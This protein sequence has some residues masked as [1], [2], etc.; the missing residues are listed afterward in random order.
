MKKI[1]ILDSTLR[2]GAQGEGV[3][4]SVKDKIYICQALD[5]LGVDFIEAGNPGSN[6]PAPPNLNSSSTFWREGFHSIPNGGLEMI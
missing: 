5:E 2:D 6:L 4:F 3:S 1:E